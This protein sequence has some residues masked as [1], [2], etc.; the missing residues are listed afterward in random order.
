MEQKVFNIELEKYLRNQNGYKHQLYD[1]ITDYIENEN[2][3]TL[4]CMKIEFL[5]IDGTKYIFDA[6]KHNIFDIILELFQFFELALSQ[7]IEGLNYPII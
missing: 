2:F 4:E 3:N 7:K 5:S 6:Y 1:E